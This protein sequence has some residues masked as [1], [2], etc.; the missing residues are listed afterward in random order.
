M[1]QKLVILLGIIDYNNNINNDDETM[2][3]NLYGIRND[4]DAYY[5]LWND[6][7]SYDVYPN[8]N[9]SKWFKKENWTKS[10]V[11]QFLNEAYAKLLNNNAYN[12]LIICLAGHGDN[13]KCIISS[14]GEYINIIDDI[15]TKFECIGDNIKSKIC[16][17]YSC[18]N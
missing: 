5:K 3:K 2:P 14:N 8:T 9:D 4:I 13:N 7:F 16:I 12:G 6:R 11:K 15:Q 1:D 18:F 17:I 10:E